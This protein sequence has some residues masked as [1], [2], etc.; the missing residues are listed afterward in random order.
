MVP[1][2]AAMAC[3]VLSPTI[4]KT[5]ELAGDWEGL[6]LCA[7]KIE[8][9]TVYDEQVVCHVKVKDAKVVLVQMNKIINGKEEEMSPEPLPMQFDVKAQTLTAHVGGRKPS[10]WTFRLRYS[11]W[12]GTAQDSGGTVFRNILVKRR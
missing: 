7:D 1:I 6:S 10:D 12:V 9:P 11:T 5:S 2:I 8:F 3:L 4:T